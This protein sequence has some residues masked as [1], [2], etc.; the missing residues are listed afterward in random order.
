[1]PFVKRSETGAIVAVF[2]EPVQ[3]GLEEILPDSSE[4]RDFVRE[5]LPEL[6][7][8]QR[9]LESDL[10]L[11]RVLEDVIEVL[12]AKGVFMFTDLPD[13]AQKKLRERHGLRREY[14]YVESLFSP[15]DETLGDSGEKIL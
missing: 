1:M 9:W 3:D 7:G 13:A 11:A 10:S 15:E 4:L 12:I 6:A 2:R 8:E 14:A 5:T